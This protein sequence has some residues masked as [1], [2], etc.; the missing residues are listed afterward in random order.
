MRKW[1]A[2]VGAISVA[3]ALCLPATAAPQGKRRKK[4]PAPITAPIPIT[5]DGHIS[6]DP[7]VAPGSGE[8]IVKVDVKGNLKID[9]EAILEKIGSKPGASL[10]DEQVRKDIVAIHKLG[11][12]DEIKVDMDAGTLTYTVKERPAINR[13]IFFGNDQISTDDLKGVLSIKTYDIYDENLVRESVR[14]LQKHYEDKGYY[15]AI[16]YSSS[17]IVNISFTPPVT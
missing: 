6:A 7:A 14:K 8:K 17:H 4:A 13:I 11:Y 12:F 9:R 2:G 16:G 3:F 10:D 1:M 5:A 15:L